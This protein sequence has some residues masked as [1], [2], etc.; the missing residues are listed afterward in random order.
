MAG[1]APDLLILVADGLSSTGVAANANG[2][3]AALVPLA[4]KSGWSLAPVL[5]AAQVALGD[6]A[7]GGRWALARCSY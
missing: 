6:D 5:L 3:I 7:G 4:R 2:A 1:G